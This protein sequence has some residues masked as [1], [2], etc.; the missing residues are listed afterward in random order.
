MDLRTADE[1]EMS[2]LNMQLGGRAPDKL[3]V[4]FYSVAEQ[5]LAKSAE[6]GRPIF[7]ERPFIEI[8]I[9]GNK[10]EIRCRPARISAGKFN[11]DEFNASG[12]VNRLPDDIRFPRQWAAFKNNA[13]QP[14][15]GTPLDAVPFL[16]KAQVAEFK[17]FNC[18]TAENVRDMPD[19]LAMKFMGM[20]DLR[21]RIGAFL[22]GIQAQRTG[23]TAP[24]A[25]PVAASPGVVIP[26]A[27]P[28][29][30][31]MA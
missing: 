18:V 11:P 12:D 16:T 29:L 27:A 28:P 23:L 25:S 5:D 2:M 13:E 6:E 8:R 1:H 30:A 22:D 17:A 4:K 14:I 24:G 10:D 26:V 19:G 15:I 9:P 31:R 21:R 3:L 7:I 20:H